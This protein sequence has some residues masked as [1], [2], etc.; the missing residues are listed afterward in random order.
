MRTLARPSSGKGIQTFNKSMSSRKLI[1]R[2]I[3]DQNFTALIANVPAHAWYW[4]VMLIGLEAP[5]PPA[6]DLNFS[7]Q[8]YMTYK[9]RYFERRHSTA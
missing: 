6:T 9:V 2:T 5:A 7:L 1:G 8:V 4:H 3:A